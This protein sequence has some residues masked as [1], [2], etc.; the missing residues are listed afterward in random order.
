[1]N[2]QLACFKA[3]HDCGR[4]LISGWPVLVKHG[5]EFKKNTA[6]HVCI[7]AADR[8]LAMWYTG[9]EKNVF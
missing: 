1:L 9:M 4:C 3:Y 5:P 8:K 7:V 2:Q 6:T